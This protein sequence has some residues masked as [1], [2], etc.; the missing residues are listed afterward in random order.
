MVEL[1]KKQQ[2]I[3]KAPPS[4]KLLIDAGPGTGKTEV[5]CAR[6]AWLIQENDV[7]PHQILFVSFTRAA[8]KESRQRIQ[9]YLADSN[10]VYSVRMSTLDSLTGQLL[11]AF[12][13]PKHK[14]FKS[15][16]ENIES[17]LQ[18]IQDDES[19]KEYLA[20][21]KHIFVDEGQD[22]FSVRSNLVQELIWIISSNGGGA[23][24]FFDQAQSIYGWAESEDA[25][26]EEDSEPLNLPTTLQL[27]ATG[28]F[29]VK[30]L[31]QIHR[32]S[33]KNLLSMYQTGREILVSDQSGSLKLDKIKNLVHDKSEQTPEIDHQ[34]IELASKAPKDAFFL[35]PT[36]GEALQASSYMEGNPHRVILTDQ[37]PQIF[38]WLALA[39]W[40]FTSDSISKEDFVE[41]FE[42]RNLSNLTMLSSS[43]CWELL[44][45]FAEHDSR[46]NSIDMDMLTRRLGVNPPLEF[47]SPA[48]GNSGPIFSTI[49]AAKGLEATDVNLYLQKRNRNDLED[50]QLGIEARVVF[51]GASRAKE[52]LYL[53]QSRYSGSKLKSGRAKL[54]NFQKKSRIHVGRKGD[55]DASGLVGRDCFRTEAEA[56]SAQDLISSF[57]DQNIELFTR[58]KKDRNLVHEILQKENLAKLGQFSEQLGWDLRHAKGRTWRE[59]SSELWHLRTL[60]LY[61]IVVPPIE[62]ERAKLHYP[63]NQS[64][65][66]LAPSIVGF[67]M[68]RW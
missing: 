49:H 50:Y 21:F 14:N 34:I 57:F 9:K 56:S 23:T 37:P 61:S 19:L 51:V 6:T 45:E 65:F 10:A 39:F 1:N 17:L 32:S 35:F 8:I 63:W 26:E 25:L 36:R 13:D 40:D 43:E 20:E 29:E 5:A 12:G 44:F 60:G 16:D 68:L 4:A 33:D 41:I 64:G 28:E 54:T 22:T 7:K 24:V 62:S 58:P 52:R 67:P 11:S 38:P 47:V 2:E 46:R 48:M 30:S 31:D 66:V 15:Y 3:I 59:Y 55:L 42:L 53:G 18:L 27:M